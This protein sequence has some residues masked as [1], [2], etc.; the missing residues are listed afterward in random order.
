VFA[1]AQAPEDERP[2]CGFADDTLRGFGKH[3]RHTPPRSVNKHKVVAA[4]SPG[5][6]ER[7]GLAC[8]GRRVSAI[9][10]KAA[11]QV[12]LAIASDTIAVFPD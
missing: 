1:K 9:R 3:E 8:W 2:L 12:W 5:K 10:R 11:A 6:V 7:V 4:H